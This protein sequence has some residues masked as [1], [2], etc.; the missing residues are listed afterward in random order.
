MFDDILSMSNLKEKDNVKDTQTTV[1]MSKN[2][3]DDIDFAANN[4]GISTMEWIRRACQEKLDRDS[5]RSVD[6]DEIIEEKVLM[7]LKKMGYK[8]KRGEI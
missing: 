2:L 7:V 1:K 5:G 3:R 4:L 6:Q 8:D